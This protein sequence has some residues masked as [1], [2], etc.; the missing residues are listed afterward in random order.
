MLKSVTVKPFQNCLELT[1][2]LSKN[3]PQMYFKGHKRSHKS[4]SFN[5]M[6]MQKIRNFILVLQNVL[7]TPLKPAVNDQ[8][9]FRSYIDVENRTDM[10]D[11]VERNL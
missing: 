7:S 2:A 11:N 1:T 4:V 8:P 6:N 9:N 10:L 3:E 5:E